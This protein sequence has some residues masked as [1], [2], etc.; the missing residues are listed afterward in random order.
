MARAFR[1]ALLDLPVQTPPTSIGDRL[2]VLA[3]IANAACIETAC[4]IAQ[5]AALGWWD[6]VV[7]LA[8]GRPDRLRA[9]PSLLKKLDVPAGAIAEA[10]A[11]GGELAA[12][13]VVEAIADWPS[14]VTA[15]K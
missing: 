2:R 5:E 4:M 1:P 8:G 11:L 7:A 6:A 13:P 14:L 15:M 3:L 10:R 12:L 9:A